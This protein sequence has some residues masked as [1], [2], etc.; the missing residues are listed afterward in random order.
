MCSQVDTLFAASLQRLPRE[1][2]AALTRAGLDDA[3]TLANYPRAELK[4]LQERGIRVDRVAETHGG[5]GDLDIAAN[6]DVS[7]G[8][9]TAVMDISVGSC[10]QPNVGRKQME[11]AAKVES[12][13]PGVVSEVGVAVETKLHEENPGEKVSLTK[14]LKKTSA[15]QF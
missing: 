8:G 11:K 14:L 5:I 1:L 13:I 12:M 7:M 3:C 9:G 4:D 6:Y 10:K 15:E 2:S